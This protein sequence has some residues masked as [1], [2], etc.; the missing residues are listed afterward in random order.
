[1]NDNH[2]NDPCNDEDN[3]SEEKYIDAHSNSYY[4]TDEYGDVEP[5]EKP[6]LSGLNDKIKSKISPAWKCLFGKDQINLQ[7]SRVRV[8][9]TI[10]LSPQPNEYL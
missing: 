7:M 9:V 2:H 4:E 8:L 5:E 6:N 1:M 10:S 3:C